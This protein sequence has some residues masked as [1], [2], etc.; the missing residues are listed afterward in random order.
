MVLSTCLESALLTR[1]FYI[2]ALVRVSELMAIMALRASIIYMCV[3][4]IGIALVFG[5]N[6]YLSP[7]FCILS[8]QTVEPICNIYLLKFQGR[9]ILEQTL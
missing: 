5:I 8:F 9:E 7:F 2:G 1:P 6:S 4:N 3:L